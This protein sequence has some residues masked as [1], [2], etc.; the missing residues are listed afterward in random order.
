NRINVLSTAATCPVT[1]N[2]GGGL[3]TLTVGSTTTGLDDILGN[4]TFSGDDANDVINL[5]DQANTRNDTYTLTATT[6][7]RTSFPLLSFSTTEGLTLNGGSGSST[8]NIQ[9]GGSAT[10]FTINAGDGDD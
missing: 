2:A 1:V 8:F 3:D 7:D 10:P 5:R 4:I 9:G 6:F